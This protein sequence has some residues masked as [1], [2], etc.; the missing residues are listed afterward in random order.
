METDGT[1]EDENTGENTQPPEES[2]EEEAR[3]QFLAKSGSICASCVLGAVPVGAGVAMLADPLKKQSGNAEF[4]KV[5]TMDSVPEDDTPQKFTIRADKEDAWSR[6]PD[7]VIGAVY[8][9][10]IGKKKVQAFNVVCPHLG[11][12]IDYRTEEHDYY[13]PCHNSAFELQSGA[14]EEGSPSARGLDELETKI[15]NDGSVW[16]KFQNFRMGIEE[17]IPV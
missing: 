17:K 3:R 9:R 13:C 1:D 8:L 12:A 6:F 15:D 14:Q 2:P 5:T 4:I 7:Q 11:C 16:V 10:R